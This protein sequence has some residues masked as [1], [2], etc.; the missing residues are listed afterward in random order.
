MISEGLWK[1][2]GGDSGLIGNTVALNGVANTV[3]GIAPASLS[4]LTNGEIWI[5]LLIDPAREV[6]FNRAIVAVGRIKRGITLQQAQAEMD[7]IAH[8]VGQQ[9]PEV[10][11]WGIRLVTFYHW[12]VQ[13]QLCP[14]CWYCWARWFWSC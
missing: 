13:D 10:K 12:F 11:D 5:P 4:T 1:R 14:R 8:R 3:V 6:R 2:F 9:Y 7:T